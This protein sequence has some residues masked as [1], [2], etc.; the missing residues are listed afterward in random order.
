MS[1]SNQG[2][3]TSTVYNIAYVPNKHI[4]KEIKNLRA[5]KTNDSVSLLLGLVPKVG[6]AFSV[7]CYYKNKQIDGMISKLKKIK[8]REKEPSLLSV[9]HPGLLEHGLLLVG[10]VK[11][12]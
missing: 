4:A 10:A 9:K 12:L 3:V 8:K 2:K 6:T 1:V 7:G 11:P 5:S